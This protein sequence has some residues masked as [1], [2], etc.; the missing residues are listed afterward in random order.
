[1]G[2]R[3]WAAAGRLSAVHCYSAPGTYEVKLNIM[4][5]LSESV[6][7]NQTSYPL[8]A[9]ADEQAV[10]G[11][12]DSVAT[13]AK[14]TWDAAASNLPEFSTKDVHWELGDGRKALGPAGGPRVGRC[15]APTASP[16]TSSAVRTAKVASRTTAC[17]AMC[18]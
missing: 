1:M 12:P 10:I 17:T 2:F 8:E 16:W 11:G 3:R 14:A 4:D 6:Y 15:P 9:A 5:T 7:F 18:R 13:G